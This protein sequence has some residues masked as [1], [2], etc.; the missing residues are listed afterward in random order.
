MSDLPGSSRPARP[1]EGSRWIGVALL[2]IGLLVSYFEILQPLQEAAQGVRRVSWDDG[3]SS[4]GLMSGL[5]G[6]AIAI[7]PKI[8]GGNSI[9]YKNK[10]KLSIWGWLLLAVLVASTLALL[11]HF[12]GDFAKYGYRTVSPE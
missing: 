8:M 11:S 12:H 1:F 5:L 9:F 10:S 6:A 3:L 2:V 7:H 4:M